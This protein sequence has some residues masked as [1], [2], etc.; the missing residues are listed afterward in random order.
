ML[1]PFASNNMQFV[2][3]Y[4]K[5]YLKTPANKYSS[6]GLKLSPNESTHEL[7]RVSGI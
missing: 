4:H 2:V 3:K 5:K 1:S 7:G 6:E